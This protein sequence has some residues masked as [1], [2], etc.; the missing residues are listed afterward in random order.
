MLDPT[1]A[2]ELAVLCVVV[3][4]LAVIWAAGGGAWRWAPIPWLT[5]IGFALGAASIYAWA[6]VLTGSLVIRDAGPTW[7]LLSLWFAAWP[8]LL[9]GLRPSGSVLWG[10]AGGLAA[11]VLLLAALYVLW[12]AAI[13]GSGPN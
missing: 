7:A 11:D 6:S 3:F 5:G 12:L 1:I 9:A 13:V 4:T 8:T 2:L 10:L